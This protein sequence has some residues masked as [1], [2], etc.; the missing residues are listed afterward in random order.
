MISLVITS[1]NIL[2]SPPIALTHRLVPNGS[3]NFNVKNIRPSFLTPKARSVFN[4]LQFSFIKALI[5][6]Y[7]DPKYHIWI[8]TDALGYA[9]SGMLSQL[10]SGTSPDGVITKTDL[11]Q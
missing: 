10:A 5:L 6:W 7:F 1:N 2:L 11:S 3:P 9:I 8:E 4:R